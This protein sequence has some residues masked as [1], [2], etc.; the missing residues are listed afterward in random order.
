MLNFRKSLIRSALNMAPQRLHYPL[1]VLLSCVDWRVAYPLSLRHIAEVTHERA[2]SV[3]HA[4]VH[5]WAITLPPLL[6][7]VFC[8][9]KRPV[10]TSY[11]A[12][13]PDLR[14]SCRPVKMPLS[15][16]QKSCPSDARVQ[17][18]LGC[19]NPHRWYQDNA[20]DSQGADRLPQ[21]IN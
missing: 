3:D 14:Q 8:S 16:C 4:T 2:V 5:R 18:I 11:M 20:Y 21:S 9:R 6:P 15:G 10:G 1:E 17:V 13:G 12:Y 19:T 7:A